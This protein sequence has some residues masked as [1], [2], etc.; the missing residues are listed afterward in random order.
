MT[1]LLVY[2]FGP[3]RNYRENVSEKILRRLPKRKGLRKVVFPVRFHKRQ[4]LGVLKKSDFDIVLGLGQCSRGR[5]LRIETRAVNR[6]RSDKAERP[7]P[8]APAGARRLM[9]N[10]E[11]DRDA[12]ARV[13]RDAGDYVCNFS[14]YVV[15]DFLRRRRPATRFGFIHVPHR[16]DPRRAA[17][18]LLKAIGKLEKK[19]RD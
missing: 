6:W 4:F 15:L 7:R 9:T 19:P 14:M 16:Y 11:L 5:R 17:S 10:L 13:S 2:G 12:R 18:F 8:I 1:R 3:Y